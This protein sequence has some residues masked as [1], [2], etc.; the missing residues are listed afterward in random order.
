MTYFCVEWNVKPQL[1]QS[2]VPSVRGFYVVFD[3]LLRYTETGSWK[4]AF[5]R[6]IP[7]RKQ[8]PSSS[9]VVVKPRDGNESSPENEHAESSSL[10][11]LAN[12]D[13]AND[14]WWPVSCESRTYDVCRCD[15]EI[16]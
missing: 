4:D 9:G 13:C 11:Q 2:N 5:H 8:L 16:T 1:A 6:V 10:L 12:S 15:A 14:Q 3:I 7:K